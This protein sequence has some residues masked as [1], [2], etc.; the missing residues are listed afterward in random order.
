MTTH[1][2][3]FVN[4]DDFTPSLGITGGISVRTYRV[5]SPAMD[6]AFTVDG[7]LVIRIPR[8]RPLLPLAGQFTVGGYLSAGVEAPAAAFK[9]FSHYPYQGVDP[10]MAWLGVN[11]GAL[12]SAVA[13]SY[14][15]QYAA[16]TGPADYPVSA[17]GYAWKRAAYASVGFKF[18]S[19]TANKH[20]ILDAIQFE[21]LALAGTG[22]STYQNAREI[23][24]VVKPTRLNYAS[25]PNMESGITG[26]SANGTTT[27]AGDGFCWRGTQALKVTVPAGTSSDS[28]TAFSITGLIPGRTYNLSARVATAQGC[29]DVTPWVGNGAAYKASQT[30]RQAVDSVDPDDQRWRTIWVSFTAITSSVS[31]GF[32]VV[33][34]TMSAGLSSIFWVDGV[35]TEEGD[36]ARPYFDGSMGDDYLWETG[37]T[38]NATRSYFY[39]NRVERSY[40]IRTLLTENVP[41]GI[42]SGT[43]QYAVLPTQ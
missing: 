18:A 42:S 38:V 16:F 8:P 40:L 10:A 21:K 23:Q 13:G 4:D 17:G 26:Y 14:A 35:L 36:T 6:G 12:T 20:Q 11:S 5:L 31:V 22:P 30:W 29:G 24:V 25:N 34:S 1:S 39:E 19:M 28:G 3:T 41:L 32:N 2:I 37:G 7:L 43:P 15:R 27:L 33:A 9:D